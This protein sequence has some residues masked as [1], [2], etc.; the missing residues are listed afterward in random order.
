MLADELEALKEKNDIALEEYK[1]SIDKQKQYITE[2]YELTVADIEST[3][4]TLISATESAEGRFY[5]GISNASD[6]VAGK[7]AELK[8]QWMDFIE[9]AFTP[10]NDTLRDELL[11]NASKL[12]DKLNDNLP[13]IK[14]VIAGM[15]EKA[16]NLVEAINF[17]LG[18]IEKW[19]E[20]KKDLMPWNDNGT[21]DVQ[22]QT[23]TSGN[24]SSL[25]DKI[26]EWMGRVLA[27][28]GMSGG[29]AFYDFGND[30]KNAQNQWKTW[31][32]YQ[33][34][35]SYTPSSTTTNNNKTVVLAPIMFEGN[36]SNFDVLDN[37]D[38]IS[39]ALND[40]IEMYSDLI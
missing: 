31:E 24:S 7:T 15:A 35:H 23:N 22:D 13:E 10:V 2:R 27:R 17:V 16:N 19:K 38:R 40:Q 14:E 8:T 33:K 39:T 30:V 28:S 25:G 3:H 37:L 6:T 12:I 5:E 29:G 36:S 21:S 26:L 20:L 18:A 11:P 32:E 1:K 9:E 4:S 34:E